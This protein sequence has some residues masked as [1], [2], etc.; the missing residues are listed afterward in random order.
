MLRPR[1]I[2]FDCYGTLTRFRM[3]ELTQEIYGDRVPGDRMAAFVESFRGYRLDEALGA[4]KPYVDLLKNA[5]ERTCK[6]HEIAFEEADG[7]RYYDAVP[8]WT[9]HDDVPAGLTKVAKEFP[10]VGLTNAANEQIMTNVAMYQAPFHKVI[11]AEDV[12]S[13][14]PRMKGFEDMLDILGAR[15]EELLH[16]SSSF[17]YDLMTAH[18]LGIEHKAWVKRGHEPASPF[19]GYHEID[20]IGGLPALVGL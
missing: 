1:F 16:V 5:V 12:Q 3:A 2:T 7:Q 10:L 13:Y 9:P 14:K 15:P 18:D 4:W 11:T 17:R 19:Y 6:A 8:T 20:D